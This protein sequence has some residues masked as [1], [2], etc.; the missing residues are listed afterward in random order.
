MFSSL[1]MGETTLTRKFTGHFYQII[2]WFLVHVI[3]LRAEKGERD[4]VKQKLVL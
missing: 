4:F 3:V 1:M 2:E